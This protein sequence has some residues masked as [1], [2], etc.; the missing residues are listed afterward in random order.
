MT[1]TL[2]LALLLTA[3]P[4]PVAPV[5]VPRDTPPPA[6]ENARREREL[7]AQIA[8]GA[9]T[10]L[11]LELAALMN[12]QNRFED[13]IAALR[14]AAALE[15]ANPEPQHR[16]GVYYWEKSRADATLDAAKRQY[17]IQQGLEA[18]D[19]ALAIKPDYMEA[20]TYKNILL[21]LKANAISDPIEQKRLIDE[22]DGLRNRVLVMQRDR[23]ES[24]AAA[25]PGA[26]PP[27]PPPSSLSFSEPYEQTLAR[28]QPVRVGGD[29]RTPTKTKDVK[30]VFP[31]IA[32]SARVQGVVI[33]EVVIDQDGSIANAKVL[34]SI[35]LLDEAA[36]G[37]VSQWRFAPT[38]LNGRAVGVVMTVTVNFTLME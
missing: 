23:Q 6:V 3:V 21:R 14:G 32:Q 2:V 36:L 17:Y 31:P 10:E 37:A 12:R 29:I 34:R 1:C 13:V 4:A 7:R 28:L 20:L 18:E 9:T 30:P 22:A 26:P 5:Q 16:I 27:P 19:R 15:P 35:P 38:E 11:Y 25:A 33:L 24:G 8:N